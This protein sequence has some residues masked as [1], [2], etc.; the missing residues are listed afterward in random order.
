[1]RAVRTMAFR[2]SF[3]RPTRNGVMLKGEGTD[4]VGVASDAHC[5]DHLHLFAGIFAG[6]DIMAITA[7]HP[8]FGKGMVEVKAKFGNLLAV[9]R[10][11]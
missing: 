9:A 11:A 5:L 10:T 8:P 2:A 7:D 4:F 3:A 6:M 1:M